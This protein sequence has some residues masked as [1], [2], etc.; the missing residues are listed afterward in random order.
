MAC[1]AE[2]TPSPEKV[3]APMS[4]SVPRIL[5]AALA[6]ALLVPPGPP[7]PARRADRPPW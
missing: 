7:R 3:G 6:A 1:A 5:A 2:A 4:R